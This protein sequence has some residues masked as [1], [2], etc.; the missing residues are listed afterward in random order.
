MF[1]IKLHL[2]FE[3]DQQRHLWPLLKEIIFW[4]LG[5]KSKQQSSFTAH[6]QYIIKHHVQFWAS[7]GSCVMRNR[8]GVSSNI[9]QCEAFPIQLFAGLFT[10]LYIYQWFLW[11]HQITQQ[12]TLHSI[13]L[14]LSFLYYNLGSLQQ[15]LTVR[16]KSQSV[17]FHWKLLTLLLKIFTGLSSRGAVSKN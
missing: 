2:S 12:S 8:V 4:K 5:L 7:K 6:H 13:P 17:R 14:L 16:W 11:I 15:T 1:K 3:K 10:P 9:Y